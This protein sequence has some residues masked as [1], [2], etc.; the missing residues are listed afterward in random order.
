MSTSTTSI[1]AGVA[2]FVGMDRETGRSLSGT[3]HLAQS[4]GDILSTRIGSRVERRDYGSKVPDYIDMPMTTVH[5][6]K[7]Y[8]A[9]ALAL[10]TWEPRL[11]LAR[12]Q[13]LQ[14]DTGAGLQGRHVFAVDLQMHSGPV[15]LEVPV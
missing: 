2:D 15:T 10:L 4:I 8:G 7:M 12:V 9:A 6:T 1:K 5:R 3:A 11:K 13:L 14:D